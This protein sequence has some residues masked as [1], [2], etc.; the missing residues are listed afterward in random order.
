MKRH[1][2][3][4]PLSRQHHDGLALC[5]FIRRDLGAGAEAAVAERLRQQALD[6]WDLELRG[7]FAVE[8]EVLFNAVRDKVPDPG[9]VDRLIREHAEIGDL[10]A[11]LRSASGSNLAGMLRSLGERLDAH[12]R[13][14]ER[15]LFEAVQAT[16]GE[17]LLVDLGRRIDDA[18]PNACISLGSAGLARG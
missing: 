16:V 15:V 6:L 12:I 4:V 17:E 7:H 11:S 18:L 13:F 2:A 14:E 5:V 9:A 3:L 1:A 10:M 8:E